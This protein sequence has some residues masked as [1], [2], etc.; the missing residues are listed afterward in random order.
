M[1]TIEL[2]A[3][4]G[5]VAKAGERG[6]AGSTRQAEAVGSARARAVGGSLTSCGRG[7]SRV[8][9]LV[10]LVRMSRF[11]YATPRALQVKSTEPAA[12]ESTRIEHR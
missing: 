5:R 10:S 11:L 12:R 8:M 2:R 3:Q 9:T 1:G 4:A 6:Q 7:V